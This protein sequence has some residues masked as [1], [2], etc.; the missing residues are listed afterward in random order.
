MLFGA[1]GQ[2]QLTFTPK[3][4]P[5]AFTAVRL[6]SGV[7]FIVC[8]QEHLAVAVLGQGGD[9][10]FGGVQYG[11]ALGQYDVDLGADVTRHFLITTGEQIVQTCG[12]GHAGDDANLAAV[13]RKALGQQMAG[14]A[15]E[16]GGLHAPVDQQTLPLRPIHA[17]LSGQLALVQEQAVGTGQ[18]GVQAFEVQQPGQ[19]LRCPGCVAIAHQAHHRNASVV[20][21]F[22]QVV[23]NRLAHRS[24][25]TCG[26]FEVHQ[27]ARAGIDFDHRAALWPQRLG[28]VLRHQVDPGDV[29]AHD[30]RSQHGQCGHIGVHLVGH[31]HRHVAGAHD[32]HT[33]ARLRHAFGAQ[34]LAL[35]FQHRGGVLVQANGVQRKILF[36]AAARIGVDLQ[37]DQLLHR[38]HAITHHAGG[39]TFV[40]RRHL[41][42]HH[43]QAVFFAQNETLDDDFAAF[44]QGD[45]VGRLDVFL[46]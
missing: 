10:G 11:R 43:Q 42:T 29:Q 3:A 46:A 32:Q 45:A 8:I 5:V 25:L 1:L 33:A 28:N 2:H 6:Q 15:F 7:V 27:Q 12:S 9:F 18:S 17:V 19:Q 31:V 22:E 4:D 41:V 38:V 14:V 16:H 39:L 21:G 24:G 30:T 40:G 26:R 44:S 13:I 23:G 36:L 34:T 20:F 37:L 35:E